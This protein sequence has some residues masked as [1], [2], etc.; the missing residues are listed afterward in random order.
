MLQKTGGLW[1]RGLKRGNR[2]GGCGTFFLD[3]SQT[4][5]AFA[6]RPQTTLNALCCL[7]VTLWKPW[8]VRLRRRGS[9]R[10]LSSRCLRPLV[11]L[12]CGRAIGA[13]WTHQ[14]E[15]PGAGSNVDTLVAV[16][17][18][19]SASSGIDVLLVR[20]SM[21]VRSC[22]DLHRLVVTWTRWP[23]GRQHGSSWTVANRSSESDML[24]LL[25]L[26]CVLTCL[27]FNKSRIGAGDVRDRVSNCSLARLL[28]VTTSRWCN[29]CN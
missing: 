16:P 29:C 2:S 20:N 4:L 27:P 15:Q 25:D 19:G 22:I 28:S 13:N 17:D 21:A 5:V 7:G 6:R 10:S 12:V 8:T 24:L 23:A 1:A 18:S 14:R 11:W 3:I 9:A 26:E